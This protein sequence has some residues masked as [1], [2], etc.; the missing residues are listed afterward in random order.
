MEQE[1]VKFWMTVATFLAAIG[2]GIYTFF[3][4]RQKDTDA[5]FKEG[6]ERLEAVSKRVDKLENSVEALPS[7]E[8]F[9]KLDLALTRMDGN[10][11]A[12]G[13]TLDGLGQIMIRLERIVTRHDEHLLEGRK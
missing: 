3:A 13:I 1:T 5:R 11:Q 10:I 12:Q 9:H 4:T 2:S 8:D 7:K 6:D